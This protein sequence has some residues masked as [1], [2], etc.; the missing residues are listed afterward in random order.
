MGK[1]DSLLQSLSGE[2]AAV[3]G[4]VVTRVQKFRHR[5]WK[6]N[7]GGPE[8]M[9]FGS[10]PDPVNTDGTPMK[11]LWDNDVE[12]VITVKKHVDVVIDD[13]KPVDPPV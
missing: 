2:A 9:A 5:G 12:Q 13:P 4:G 3:G 6:P 1:F 7:D 8:Q 10:D 11:K